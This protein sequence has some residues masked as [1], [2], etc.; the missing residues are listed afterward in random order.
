M[1]RL[2]KSIAILLTIGTIVPH[3]TY[4]QDNL[5]AEG[6]SATKTIPATN[7]V[8][9]QNYAMQS[10]PMTPEQKLNIERGLLED[11]KSQLI[12]QQQTY[13]GTKIIVACAVGTLVAGFLIARGGPKGSAG[14]A[15]DPRTLRSDFSPALANSGASTFGGLVMVGGA[16]A[17]GS[18]SVAITILREDI[19]R[20]INEIDS[21]QGNLSLK[22]RQIQRQKANR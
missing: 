18:G 5:F 1:S 8:T 19:G 10:L 3:T 4:A 13:V 12:I 9:D 22:L 20:I 21:I 6:D 7:Q 14:K 2:Q 11:L 16:L 17:L 15:V